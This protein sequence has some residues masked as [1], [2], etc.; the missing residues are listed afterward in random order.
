MPASQPGALL[1][2]THQLRSGSQ[3]LSLIELV[4]A[5]AKEAGPAG[6]LTL[7]TSCDAAEMQAG[8]I[9]QTVKQKEVDTL[10]LD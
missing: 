9:K 7:K 3:L 6:Y 5:A 4:T 8:G 10:S 1:L 2:T